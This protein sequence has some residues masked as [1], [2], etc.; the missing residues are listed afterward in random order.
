MEGTNS[1]VCRYRIDCRPPSIVNAFFMLPLV[2]WLD[3]DKFNL[4][5]RQ[6]TDMGSSLGFDFKDRI[7]SRS[8]NGRGA[9]KMPCAVSRRGYSDRCTNA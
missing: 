8:G 9:T 5:I 3:F 4:R 7:G 2:I 1:V 6:I